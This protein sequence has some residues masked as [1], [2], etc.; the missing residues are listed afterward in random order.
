MIYCKGNVIYLKK[1]SRRKEFHMKK[2]KKLIGFV[3]L[4]CVFAVLA[5]LFAV[6]VSAAGSNVYTSSNALYNYTLDENNQATIT[7]YL[8]NQSA[9]TIDRADRYKVIA[10]ADNAFA[11]NKNIKTLELSASVQTIGQ[12]A[13]AECTALESVTVRANAN[14]TSIGVGAFY[15]CTALKSFSL[16]DSL[17]IVGDEAFSSCTALAIDFSKATSLERIGEYAF[18][19][20]GT[21]SADAVTVTLP[22]GLHEIG[23]GAFY[24]MKNVSAF[25]VASGNTVYT[26][27][28]G[29]LYSAGGTVL[30]LHPV[31]P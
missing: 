23:Y 24:G 30:E 1:N 22:A 6:N 4:I 25:E 26:A 8:G 20:C 12:E 5:S 28:D 2:F 16:P 21:A 3:T 9:V 18:S 10:I 7:K 27:K 19:A 17:K 15:G 11:G 14:L 29:I 31:R 13:F